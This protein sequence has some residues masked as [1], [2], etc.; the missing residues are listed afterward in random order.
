MKIAEGVHLIASGRLGV[1]L[2]H[3]LDCNAYAVRCG[4]R[5]WLI[6]SGVGCET[7]RIFEQLRA[8]GIDPADVEALL[9]T[10][11]HL[12]HSGGAHV[13]HTRHGISVWAGMETAKAVES[14]DEEAISLG[15]AK[16][17]GV[18]PMDFP[19]HA[20]PVERVLEEGEVFRAGDEEIQA[21]AAPGHSRDMM[22]YLVR[23]SDTAMLFPGDV[24]FHGGTVSLQATHDCDTFAYAASLR[25]LAS[26]SFD[27]MF[28][29]HGLWAVSEGRRH[30]DAA[31]QHINRLLL[32]PSL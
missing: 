6:D 21:I 22:V 12:D 29:G 8:D 4:S 3:P 28:P 7:E 13:M 9:L 32:P 15:A 25:R 23:V 30:V 16:R 10:H 19:F 26:L 24:V 11:Y 14:A 31:M 2:T 5:Y 27:M 20:C 18:Y 17:A 1:S